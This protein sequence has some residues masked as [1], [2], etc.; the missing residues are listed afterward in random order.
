MFLCL[1]KRIL[2]RVSWLR[3]VSALY[4]SE[5]VTDVMKEANGVAQNVLTIDQE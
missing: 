1:T 4:T 3:T 2:E 5:R